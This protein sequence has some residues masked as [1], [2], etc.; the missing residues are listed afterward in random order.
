M[1]KILGPEGCGYTDL[2]DYEIEQ[3]IIRKELER[4]EGKGKSPLTPSASGYCERRLAYASM[5]AKGYEWYGAK[6]ITPELH[7]LF[8]LGHAVEY[9]ALKTFKLLKVVEQKYKQQILTF[10]PLDKIEETDKA[11]IVEGQ[12]DFVFWSEKHKAIGDVK[13]KKDKFSYAY[14]TA[15]A[16]DDEKFKMMNSL[17][18]I[19]PTCFY[20]DDLDAF[21]E[22]LGDDFLTDN[23]YQLNLYAN[24]DFI[25]SRGVDHAF[26]YQ[27]NKNDSRHREIRFRPSRKAYEYVKNKFNNVH[28][29]VAQKK[30][31]LT[32]REYF[33]GSIRCAFCPYKTQCWGDENTI[34]A[35]FDKMPPKRWP[36]DV[37]K[38]KEAK[39]AKEAFLEYESH[40]KVA[41]KLE[42]YEQECAELMLNE[43]IKKVKLEN[44]HIY[45]LKLLKTPHQHYV[46]RK[47][48]L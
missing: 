21:I 38:M 25:L 43:K 12:C 6:L 22:E 32:E 4:K 33:V 37:W 26:L 3:E 40:S 30:P 2:L 36:T 39:R 31:E 18:Q 7:R 13:S 8:E 5:E 44:G 28:K 20:A 23:L 34:K 19:S 17:V 27:Y 24:S 42:D 10:F 47:G 14:K 46:L 1:S 45:E 11:Q 9:T 48:K 35:Y 15:W 29:A 16:E 41:E